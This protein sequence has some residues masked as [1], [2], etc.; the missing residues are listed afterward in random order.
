[1]PA[2]LILVGV[3]LV[4]NAGLPI[5][6]YEL[7]TAPKLAKPKLL[8]PVDKQEVLAKGEPNP[9]P[10]NLRYANNWFV[11][12]SNAPQDGVSGVGYYN[13]SVPKLKIKDAS[14]E[15]AGNDLAQNLIHYQGT[16]LPGQLGNA[17]VFG[18]S[19]LPQF[20][21]PEN[22]LTIFSKLPTLEKGDEITVR[23]DGITYRYKVETMFEVAPTDIQILEQK[24]DD[25]Y[26]TLIT[27]TPPGTYRKRLIVR[28]RLIPQG[29]IN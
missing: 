8:S 11:G 22:Y 5:L 16:A 4:V 27:C 1:M 10:L 20:F 13:L 29:Q 9:Y 14:V 2:L 26:L 24:Y 17:I 21:D 19:V 6:S 12:S 7:F 28:A 18:H 15:I 25:S 23:Y 3:A